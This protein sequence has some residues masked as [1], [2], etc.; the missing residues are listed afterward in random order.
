LA[1]RILFQIPP[2]GGEEI[3]EAF[4]KTQVF[5][6]FPALGLQGMKFMKGLWEIHFHLHRL[7]SRNSEF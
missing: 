7:L 4:A 6:H 5:D 3:Y 2:S 1:E